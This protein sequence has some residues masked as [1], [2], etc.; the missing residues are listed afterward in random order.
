MVRDDQDKPQQDDGFRACW[1]WPDLC[2]QVGLH[3]GAAAGLLVVLAGCAQPM[4][5][6]A[7]N[8]T[9]LYLFRFKNHD[10][11]NRL[12]LYKLFIII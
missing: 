7:G 12:H 1:R 5:V 11:R 6:L 4:T 9:F 3:L 10:L 8:N 2:V